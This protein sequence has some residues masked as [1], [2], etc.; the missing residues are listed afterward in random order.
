MKLTKIT[1][2]ALILITLLSLFIMLIVWIYTG[3]YSTNSWEYSV[4]N[5]IL[6]TRHGLQILTTAIILDIAWEIIKFIKN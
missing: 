6:R 3:L 1:A 4:I 2:S 5:F